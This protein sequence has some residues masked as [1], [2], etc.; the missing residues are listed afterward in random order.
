MAVIGHETTIDEAT[1][2][3]S[4]MLPGHRVEIPSR[5]NHRVTTAG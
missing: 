5:G 2:R 3:I 4:S 1:D